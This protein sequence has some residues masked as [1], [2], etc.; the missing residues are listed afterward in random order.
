M[1]KNFH[2]KIPPTFKLLLF[3]HTGT[4]KQIFCLI[5]VILR[6]FIIAVD[7]VIFIDK[8]QFADI[9]YFLLKLIS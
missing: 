9:F 7:M 4:R 1:K 5:Y 3:K 2:F 6:K 8:L